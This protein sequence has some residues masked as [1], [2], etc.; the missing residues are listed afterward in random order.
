MGTPAVGNKGEMIEKLMER[1]QSVTSNKVKSI[2]SLK[3]GLQH[4]TYTKIDKVFF[5][6]FFCFLEKKKVISTKK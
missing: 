2:L 5:F 1:Y 6:F 4:V 3:I